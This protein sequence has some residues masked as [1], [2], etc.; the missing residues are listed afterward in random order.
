MAAGG[1]GRDDL[2]DAT[3]PHDPVLL[4]PV[5]AHMAPGPE[6]I[7]VDGTFGA[8][9]YS[10]ALLRAGAGRVWAL[11]R[12]PT[13][14]SAAGRLAEAYP[15]RF[16]WIRG[17]FGAMAALLAQEGVTAVDGIVLDLGVSSMQLDQA[18]RG[19][20]FRRDG[21]LDMR[22]AGSTDDEPSA[23]D[24]V[25]GLEER[26]LARLL[27]E[28]GEEKASRRIA[29]AILARRK[30]HP[31]R[32]TAE[33]AAVV[34]GVLGDGSRT[35]GRI[36][37]ATRTFQA[38]RLAVND[39]LGELDR[40][41]AGS[42]GLLRP[43]GRLVVVSFHSLEDRRVKTFLRDYSD[44]APRPSRHRPGASLGGAE[45][46][47]T[48]PLHLLTRQAV[49]PDAA[50]IARNPRAR[51]SRLRAAARTAAPVPASLALSPRS[52]LGDRS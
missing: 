3:Q 36:D 13:V 47:A 2:V 28:Y 18:E 9:G 52:A 30:E 19:F 15:G 39:E 8:G 6:G 51:S 49:K 23:A 7:Y 10:Q 22:M 44:A 20:S 41:L 16:G 34:H 29:R 33:L 32:T 4:Q 26:E 31:F 12:D 17:C 43:G 50:E 45:A 27:W 35:P 1:S 5:L 42:L 46:A 25:N 14:A 40:A 38:L 37:P 11:D 24:L 21:P 48:A